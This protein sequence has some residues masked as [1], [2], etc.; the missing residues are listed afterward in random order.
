MGT[1]F[2]P[3]ES[4]LVCPSV[5]EFHEE[6]DLA[7]NLIE[8]CR[9][10]YSRMWPGKKCDVAVSQSVNMG[11]YSKALDH[12]S[13]MQVLLHPG[14]SVQQG[15]RNA[16]TALR[17]GAADGSNVIVSYNGEQYSLKAT[18]KLRPQWTAS[19]AWFTT[20]PF[21]P[22][23]ALPRVWSARNVAPPFFRLPSLRTNGSFLPWFSR[24]ADQVG[25]VTADPVPYD[26][27]D[28]LDQAIFDSEDFAMVGINHASPKRHVGAKLTLQANNSTVL[29]TEFAA[30][31]RH[32]LWG[33][34]EWVGLAASG[35]VLMNYGLKWKPNDLLTVANT[36]STGPNFEKTMEEGIG[37]TVV[38]NKTSA[39]FKV[40]PNLT[41]V[42]A[43]NVQFNKLR[44]S[45]FHI[46]KHP[47][48][49][50]FHTYLIDRAF[51][52]GYE[53][54]LPKSRICAELNSQLQ[55][56]STVQTLTGLSYS[57]QID[58]LHDVYKFGFG[59]E[60]TKK[61]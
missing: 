3:L 41:L 54:V 10:V 27:A 39:A 6:S 32:N 34:V 51:L 23:V 21:R 59:Y 1:V 33:C 20:T 38:T 2:P 24:G 26:P 14:S 40:N 31:L 12:A 58:Y 52:Q 47:A 60:L 56:K 57:G 22:L 11:T 29:Y 16:A 4:E 55:L 45:L 19:C 42:G 36:V 9:F 8:G 17:V 50:A 7:L 5:D 37:E 15:G 18:T 53:Y 25:A 49:P 30:R 48:R 46:V 13:I 61:D 44:S 43:A 35:A 28:A